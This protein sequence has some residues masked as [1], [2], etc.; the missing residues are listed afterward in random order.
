M[1]ILVTGA[2]GFVGGAFM[3]RFGGRDDLE[4]FGLGRRAT[5]W[6][7]Y[8]QV[9]LCRPFDLP[10]TPDVVLHAAARAAPW[11]TPR[12]FFEQNVLA[13]R[14]VIE[15]CHRHG[16]PRLLYVSSSSVFYREAH[17]DGLRESSPIGPRFVNDYAATKHQ[18]ELELRHY[19]GQKV[20]LRPRAVFGPGDTVLFP[21]ILEAARRG[22]LPR[23]TGQD[24]PVMGDLIYIDTLCDYLLAAAR[25]PGPQPAYNLTNGEPVDIQQLLLDTLRRLDLPAPRRQVKVRTALA[26]ASVVEAVWRLLRLPAEPPLTRFGV[27]VFA[28]RK[29]FDPALT[30]RDLGPPTVSLAEGVERFVRWQRAQW[31]QEPSR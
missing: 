30:Q 1:K 18:G 5:G 23:F 6:P 31:A 21:R 20:V 2:S 9:D 4:L 10:F 15:F 22:V 19:R 16:L 13:T 17:Q 27:G 29:T 28:Y 3:R 26:L 12:E 25:H 14:H 24:G 11:G 8:A 7:N